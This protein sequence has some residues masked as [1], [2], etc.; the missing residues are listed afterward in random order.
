MTMDPVQPPSPVIP[1]DDHGG[2]TKQQA[3]LNRSWCLGVYRC[4][5]RK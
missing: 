3:K 5:V 4:Y 2:Q 1:G